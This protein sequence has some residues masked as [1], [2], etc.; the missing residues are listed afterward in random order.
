VADVNI[1]AYVTFLVPGSKPSNSP[2]I[3]RQTTTSLL[4]VYN[5]NQRSSTTLSQRLL[6]QIRPRLV[7]RPRNRPGSGH[8]PT[9]TRMS[10]GWQSTY[11]HTCTLH[12]PC[13]TSRRSCLAVHQVAERTSSC[14]P[15]DTFLATGAEESACIRRHV[16][17]RGW[18]EGVGGGPLS[19]PTAVTSE[20]VGPPK[21]CDT[22]ICAVVRPDDLCLCLSDDGTFSDILETWNEE[23]I[24]AGS[25]VQECICSLAVV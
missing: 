23:V 2:T 14:C 12:A 20:G 21:P 16:S 8:K 9:C 18:G 1:N 19:P 22:R 11:I 15:T 4:G 5:N 6:R 17:A 24:Y 13:C 10:N 7:K 3:R 25:K